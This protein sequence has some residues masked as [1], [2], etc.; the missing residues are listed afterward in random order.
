M[1]EGNKDINISNCHN[2]TQQIYLTEEPEKICEF[3][4]LDFSNWINFDS[5]E[6]I[7]NWIC[8]SPFFSK[9]IY[10]KLNNKTRRRRD[11]RPM[12]GR[13]IKWMSNLENSNNKIDKYDR[14]IEAIKYFNL[15]WKLNDLL[16][17]NKVIYE[18]RKKFNGNKII[19]KQYLQSNK[20]LKNFIIKFK[21]YIID[22]NGDFDMWLDNNNSENVDNKLELFYFSIY[23]KEKNI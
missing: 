4:Q 14:R 16:E 10:E 2:F 5:E 7:F 21:K 17:L 9:K 13:F 6:K 8:S 23:N 18:R 12:Y 1:F 22:D 11:V 3:F 19:E 15:E 20:K